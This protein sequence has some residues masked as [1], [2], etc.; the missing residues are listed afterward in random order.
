M[1]KKMIP[2]LCLMSLVIGLNAFTPIID[3][4][5][6]AEWG[7]TPTEGT[8]TTMQ[9]TNFN[10][11]G[12]CYVTDD[13][14]Y[15]Y[16]GIPTD[17]DPWGDGNSIHFHLSIDIR[18]TAAG[19]TG[20]AWGSQVHYGQ[21]YLPDFDIICQWNDTAPTPGYTGFMTWNGTGWDQVQLDPANI[22]GGGGAFTEIAIPRSMLDNIDLNDDINVSLW[23]RPAWNKNNA[24]ACCPADASFPSDYGDGAGGTQT[25]QFAYTVSTQLA[26]TTAPRMSSA[27]QTAPDMVRVTFN[28]PMGSGAQAAG[29]YS[30][31]NGA[32]I[33]NVSMISSS[34]YDLTVGGL[35]AGTEYE[36]TASSAIMDAS[37]N[38]IDPSYNSDTFTASAYTDV[39]FTI[40][41]NSRIYEDINVKGSFDEWTLHQAYDDGTNG[42]PTAGDHSW[43]C[44][45][46]NVAE[47]SWEWGAIEDDG[48]EY[49]IWLIDGPNLQFA[50]DNTGAITG[51]TS[52]DIAGGIAQDVEVTFRVNIG[53]LEVD[54]IS[55]Q[56]SVLP[57]NWTPGSNLLTDVDNDKVY[58]TTITFPTGSNFDVDYKF[59]REIA[60]EREWLWEDVENRTFTIDDTQSSMTLDTVY[61]NNQQV[62]EL[63]AVSFLDNTASEYTNFAN[64]D[65]LGAGS[66]IDIEAITE[67]AD[68]NGNSGFGLTLRY[69]VN[70]GLEQS[71]AFTWQ[72][73]TDTTSFWRVS[74]PSEDL[75][76]GDEVL[77]RI[78]GT[79]YN[80][81]VVE[82]N[83][84]G[85]NYSVSIGT[86]GTQQDVDVTF[87]FN[88]GSSDA[89]Q[90]GI[91]GTVQPLGESGADNLM[92][93]DNGDKIFTKTVTFPAGSPYSV[94][95]N[96][97]RYMAEERS[98]QIEPSISRSFNLDDVTGT[99]DLGVEYWEGVAVS[100]LTDVF[101]LDS[102]TSVYSNF[103]SG[104]SVEVDNNIQIE[105]QVAGEDVNANSNF[106]VTLYYH[107][108]SGELQSKSFG[109]ASNYE[110]NSWWHV[111]LENGVDV[112]NGDDVSF[113]IE[114][115]DYNGPVITDNNEGSSYTVSVLGETTSQDVT[116]TFSINIGALNADSIS[117]QGSVAPLDWFGGSM[118]M[119]DDDG[120][121]TYT[122]DV[123]FPAGSPFTVQYK[124]TRLTTSLRE[125][126]WEYVGNRS[127]QI[128]D[129]ESTQ[130]L[131]L[132]YWNLNEVHELTSVAFADS[133]ASDYTNFVSGDVLAEGSDVLIETKT[134]GLDPNY[135]SGFEVTLHYTVNGGAEQSVVFNWQGS[136]P[137]YSWWRIGL[138][139]GVDIVDND[140]IA[141]WITATDYNGPEYTDNN[142]GAN[143]TVTVGQA[144][145]PAAPQNVTITVVGSDVQ[146]SWQAVA[147]A[148]NYRLQSCASPDGTFTNVMITPN[149]SLTIIGGAG[150]AN[151]KF[152]RVKA[153][154]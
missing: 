61:W 99:M 31:D 70:Q 59:T 39:T 121:C 143:Y 86:S 128:D 100:E 57:L 41:D 125:W 108:N 75:D 18:N 105:A 9:P 152:Y 97:A 106:Q 95:Y 12:G 42:D 107:V 16:F 120:D 133:A 135:N 127:F 130:V 124:F 147:G 146:L 29:N 151:M 34:V 142:G 112:S 4:T 53:G 81:P 110:G 69:R 137:E 103:V 3:G 38:P 118:P 90:V 8:F 36:L 44:V 6:D 122:V 48:S 28:E 85:Q 20:D 56:G 123:F 55:I 23:Q 79:D 74:I 32:T 80:G 82:D 98:W 35:V 66:S 13:S 117:V 113:Y 73:N 52:Y 15:I 68:L 14:N 58:E 104:G 102:G 78:T 114:A 27:V 67:G 60:S 91:V 129:S 138:E 17:V 21:T 119:N 45:V 150:S 54:N 144:A 37:G 145:P 71:K 134:G 10:L 51:D 141:F 149:T 50:I 64:G 62:N 83:N 63:T 25:T 101:F 88:L 94:S 72:T 116:V 7:E 92:V 111:M 33:N 84:G 40:N 76:E 47:G 154:Q 5:K 30:I 43:T 136:D 24:N 131:E 49:G 1:I 65:E 96:Y 89:T 140:V 139:N 109:W 93:D 132:D 19:G 22:A 46:T 115:S 26:D 77:F 11:E 87:T 2:L 148:T 126:A 153:I